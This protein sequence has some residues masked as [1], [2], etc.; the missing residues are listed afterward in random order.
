MTCTKI[1]QLYFC[2]ISNTDNLES[3]LDYVLF[4]AM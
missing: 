2:I 3:I 4:E 1:Q